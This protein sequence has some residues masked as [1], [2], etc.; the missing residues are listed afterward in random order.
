MERWDHDIRNYVVKELLDLKN[1]TWLEEDE[2]ELDGDD[3]LKQIS[4]ETVSVDTEGFFEFW[5]D[6][7]DLFGGHSIMVSGSIKGGLND[8]GIHG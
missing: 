7:G 8:A 4:L 6:D 5:Y 3:F 2:A 1:S